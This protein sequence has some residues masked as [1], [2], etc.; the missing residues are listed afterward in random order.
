M[1]IRRIRSGYE[2]GKYKPVQA[3]IDR[4]VL[5]RFNYIY[6]NHG[7][8]TK[9][10]RNA[11][12]IAINENELTE[13][14]AGHQVKHQLPNAPETTTIELPCE[15]CVYPKLCVADNQCAV[16]ELHR[17]TVAAVQLGLDKRGESC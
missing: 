13:V 10:I 5:A 2:R 16:N 9:L 7:D 15:D 12:V 14:A 8:I 1:S 11:F 6:P 3:Y 4:G 17:H